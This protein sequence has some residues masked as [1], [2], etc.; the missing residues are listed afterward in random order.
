MKRWMAYTAAALL[1]SSAAHAEAVKVVKHTRVPVVGSNIDSDSTE[2]IT[3]EMKREDDKASVQG[4]LLG[5][6]AKMSRA[7][8]PHITIT[9]LDKGVVW[10]LDPQAKT[11]TETPIAS[12]EEQRQKMEQR[13]S[14]KRQEQK[15]TLRVV[16]A[17]FK[18]KATGEEKTLHDWKCKQYLIDGFVEFEDTESHDRSRWTFHN[19]QWNTPETAAFKRYRETEAAFG[20]NYMA[21]LG[22]DTKGGAPSGEMLSGLMKATGMTS[23]QLAKAGASLRTEMAKVTGVS[24]ATDFSWTLGAGA[25]D[26]A[27]GKPQGKEDHPP[28]ADGGEKEQSR[29]G[30]G[31]LLGRLGGG[32]RGGDQGEGGGGL[33]IQGSTEI[34]SLGEEAGDFEV[35]ADYRKVDR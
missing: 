31:S 26:K 2:W 25:Q 16:D 10:R 28:E 23:E 15:S 3:P 24:V 17:G 21:K 7:N 27:Q 6:V 20:R 18:V 33:T 1:A 8:R 9:R 30:F 5:A 11:Y 22:V 19:E 14:P 13:Q 12:F 29:G 4:G 32:R 35:P 34:L